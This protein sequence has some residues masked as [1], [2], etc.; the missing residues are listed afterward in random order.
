MVALLVDLSAFWKETKIM[1]IQQ[2]VSQN[3]RN[4]FNKFVFR[5]QPTIVGAEMGITVG[6]LE[7]LTEGVFVVGD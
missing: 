1:V 2:I 4:R 3:S 6:L 5:C 7:G